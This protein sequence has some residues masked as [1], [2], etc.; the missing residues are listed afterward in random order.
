M[1]GV[2]SVQKAYRYPMG[3]GHVMLV[4]VDDDYRGLYKCGRRKIYWIHS[5]KILYMFA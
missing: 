1:F 2:T 4:E 3:T 5:L